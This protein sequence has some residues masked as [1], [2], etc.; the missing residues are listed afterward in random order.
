MVCKKSLKISMWIWFSVLL[1]QL[2]FLPQYMSVFPEVS[3]PSL[4]RRRAE[5]KLQDSE[6]RLS[7]YEV[8][9]R[10]RPQNVILFIGD[11]M[12]ISTV[13]G[14]RY[15]KANYHGKAA[16]EVGMEWDNWPFS[17]L[18]QT[19]S[20][21]RMTT[22]SAASATALLCGVKAANKVLGITGVPTCCSCRRLNTTS[23]VKSSLILAQE[24]GLSTGIVTTSR[25]TDATPAAAYANSLHRK[26]EAIPPETAEN[27]TACEDIASQMVKRGLDFNVILGGGYRKFYQNVSSTTPKEPGDRTDG[28]N[29]LEEWVSEQHRRGR[30]WQLIFNRT[31]LL[32][33]NVA[34]T[35]YLL[36]LFSGSYM[37]YDLLRTDQPSLSEMTMVAIDILSKNPKGY[38]LL[39]EGA[40]IDHGHHWNTAKIALTDTTAMEDAVLVAVEETDPDDTLLI[41]TADHSQ[42]YGIVGYG[43]RDLSVLDVDYTL[44]GS[45]GM[46]YLISS[47]FN[48]PGGKVNESRDD[49]NTPMRFGDK[50][51][52]Q[53]LVP[54]VLSTHAAE[55]VA[56]YA[57]GPMGQLIHGTMDNTHVAHIT[58]YSLCLG[59]YK[60]AQHC[61]KSLEEGDSPVQLPPHFSPSPS[62]QPSSSHFSP[63]LSRS[64]HPSHPSSAPLS[65]SSVQ[66][67]R[68]RAYLAAMNNCIGITSP[69][70]L[71]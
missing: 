12:G 38:F 46:R 43:T 16:G 18:V 57:K 7:D 22:D 35:D 20:A 48:G 52:Q 23:Y 40:R 65:S 68:S 50:F 34:N 17:A 21:D 37:D 5:R 64:S 63:E 55:D 25:V 56:I 6:K 27:N 33:V 62:L 11:G 47:Y 71:K 19:Y 2:V 66:S 70:R 3:D 10:R 1:W 45:D 30:H 51:V 53:A 24:A 42:P 54:M 26:W 59:S 14:A 41:V 15:L 69:N 32:N 31:E 9:G 58:M 60:N 36:G 13:T 67:G 28:R 61:T 29:L 39:V 44:M 49:P 8:K 4:S